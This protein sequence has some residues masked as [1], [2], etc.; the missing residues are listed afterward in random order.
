MK[1]TLALL[2]AFSFAFAVRASA[3][4][5]ADPLYITISTPLTPVYISTTGGVTVIEA[6]ETGASYYLGSVACG[7]LLPTAP[8]VHSVATTGTVT[9]VSSPP[10][11]ESYLVNL[12]SCPGILPAVATNTATVALGTNTFV[13]TNGI[14]TARAAVLVTNGMPISVTLSAGVTNRPAV[15]F[16]RSYYPDTNTLTLSFIQGSGTSSYVLSNSAP[17]AA[18]GIWVS[19]GATITATRSG[20]VT[21]LPVLTFTRIVSPATTSVTLTGNDQ[22]RLYGA[23]LASGVVPDR[24]GTNTVTIT[25]AYH[26]GPTVAFCSFTNGAAIYET[27]T[28]PWVLPWDTITA[29]VIG[30]TNSPVVRIPCERWKD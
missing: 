23:R 29:T 3:G 15:T 13:F 1:N 4:W 11:G 30:A 19:P 6:P 21:N 27:S 18:A 25:I 2:I 16:Y 12:L 26:G 9:V 17:S 5:E 20:S 22:R 8:L 7:D 10:V 28:P 24:A 14:T